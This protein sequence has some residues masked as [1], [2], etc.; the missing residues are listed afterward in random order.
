MEGQARI[1]FSEKEYYDGRIKNGKREGNG[2]YCYQ[3]G[4]EFRGEWKND[5]KMMGSYRF[6]GGASFEGR[7]KKNEMNYGVMIYE[8]GE[9]YEG[10]FANGERHGIGCYRSKGGE[11][12]WEGKWQRD[13]FV[14]KI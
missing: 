9:S 4:D 6:S 14:C 13:V 7:F 10:E 11:L 2:V 3:N 12:L 1:Q 8:N 5:Q